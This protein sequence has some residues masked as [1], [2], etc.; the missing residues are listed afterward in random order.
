M[1]EIVQVYRCPVDHYEIEVTIRQQYKCPACGHTM[2]YVTA[3][4]R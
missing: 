3:R 2:R 4:P 1:S